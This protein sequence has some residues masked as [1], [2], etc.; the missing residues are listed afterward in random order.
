MK[1]TVCHHKEVFQSPPW[2]VFRSRFL[3]DSLVVFIFELS[4]NNVD[5][6]LQI[7][8][9]RLCELILFH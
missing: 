9:V 8:N 1:G 2:G 7:V 6:L 4:A 3:W 5:G